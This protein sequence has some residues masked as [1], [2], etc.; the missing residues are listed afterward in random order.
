[1]IVKDVFKYKSV[2]QFL[3]FMIFIL[4]FE[5]ITNWDYM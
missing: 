2:R 5:P 3:N 4:S 1:M